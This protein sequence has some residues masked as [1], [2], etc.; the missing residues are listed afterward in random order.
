MIFLLAAMATAL[1]ST[2]HRIYPGRLGTAF[3]IK[4][5]VPRE[6]ALA[7]G[8]KALALP[9][10]AW[11]SDRHASYA[12]LDC[13]AHEVEPDFDSIVW[14]RVRDRLAHCYEVPEASLCLID[15]FVVRYDADAG[16]GAELA[17]H[18]DAGPLSFLSLIHI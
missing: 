4:G 11:A 2:S 14:S 17:P 5:C 13:S 6:D 18:R 1:S 16:D 9:P 12:T 7:I 3:R 8:K 10:S 15:A